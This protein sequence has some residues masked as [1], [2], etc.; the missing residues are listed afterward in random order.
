[1]WAPELQSAARRHTPATCCA[2]PVIHVNACDVRALAW[3][4]DVAAK[5]RARFGSDIVINV[6]GYRRRG[7]NEM[8]SEDPALTHPRLYACMDAVDDVVA[9]ANRA[10]DAETVARERDETE[11]TLNVA[12]LR[13]K[14]SLQAPRGAPSFGAPWS[15]LPLRAPRDDARVPTGVARDAFFDALALAHA[16][17]PAFVAHDRVRTAFDERRSRHGAVSFAA[18][19]AVALATLA[20]EGNAVRVC[21]QDSARGVYIERFGR[22]VCQHSGAA[23]SPLAALGVS[24]VNSPLTEN[25]VLG[26][27]FGMSWHSP[28]RLNVWEAQ[29]GDHFN[30]AQAVIDGFVSACRERWLWPSAVVLLLPHGF[31]GAGAEHSSARV[32]RFLAMSSE[33]VDMRAAF[34][35]DVNWHVVHPS[36]SAQY[37]HVLRRQLV[38]KSRKPL[39]VL[40][41]KRQQRESLALS[42]IEEMLDDT[43]F[44]S[45]IDDG[46]FAGVAAVVVLCSGQTYFD[47]LRVR[48]E[49]Q[50]VGD[51]VLVRVEEMC[52]FPF[53]ALDTVL[54]RYPAEA[55]VVWLQEEAQ[56]GGAFAY[57]VPRVEQLIAPRRLGFVGRP[58]SAAPATGMFDQHVAEINAIKNALV[59]V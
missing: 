26:F 33:P 22:I 28:Q 54:R 25:A 36:T 37:F 23:H 2:A 11:A 7:H 29:L 31:V 42:P 8:M 38:R 3:A 56:N 40:G 14:A 20:R 44:E 45:V 39:I 35:C 5:Y 49:A 46:T 41:P 48:A 4:G 10:R 43:R 52:P 16:L 50:R 15:D 32:D 21:G 24:Y 18:A 55:R 19:E 27:E 51:M 59:L 57:V 34:A 1:M 6:C 12:W 13:A 58:A 47:A 9:R 17:P 30:N 53:D